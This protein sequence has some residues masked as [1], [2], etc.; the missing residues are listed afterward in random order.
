MSWKKQYKRNVLWTKSCVQF[1]ILNYFK[2]HLFQLSSLSLISISK[3]KSLYC[4]SLNLQ[5]LSRCSACLSLHF[6]GILKESKF[7]KPSGTFLLVAY[8]ILKQCVTIS[9]NRFYHLTRLAEYFITYL[10]LL[11]SKK[12]NTGHNGHGLLCS[13]YQFLQ[14]KIGK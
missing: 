3:I 11:C 8:Q 7:I 9:W 14:N 10:T 6:C 12:Y 1:K 4:T 5:K 2:A 13:F